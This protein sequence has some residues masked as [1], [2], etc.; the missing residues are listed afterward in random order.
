MNEPASSTA[1]GSRA[2]ADV[3]EMVRSMVIELSPERVE[4]AGTDA[5]LID[6]LA[7][8]SLALV[9]L[10]FTLE[11]EFDL[12]PIQEATARQITTLGAVADHVVSEL[13]LRGELA[14]EP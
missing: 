10:A 14:R 4:S 9:E 3:R 12:A 7:F 8:N 6:D 2:E 13:A 5:R 11:D 1:A